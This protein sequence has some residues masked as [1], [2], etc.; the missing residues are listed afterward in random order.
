MDSNGGCVDRI[1]VLSG[2]CVCVGNGGELSGGSDGEIMVV[3]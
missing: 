1:G 3:R 2:V